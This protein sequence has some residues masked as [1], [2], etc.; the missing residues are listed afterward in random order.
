MDIPDPSLSYDFLGLDAMT[1]NPLEKARAAYAAICLDL[2][3]EVAELYPEAW[4][5][6]TNELN[7]FYKPLIEEQPWDPESKEYFHNVIYN[8]MIQATRPMMS[9][10]Q[11]WTNKKLQIT[12]Y[13]LQIP[14]RI[15]PENLI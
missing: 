4:A 8:R 12:N 5:E 9:T 13:R 1:G 14:I 2:V 15:K 11:E 10:W 6:A 7:P 3:R